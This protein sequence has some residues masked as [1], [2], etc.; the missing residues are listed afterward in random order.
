MC[1]FILESDTFSKCCHWRWRGGKRHCQHQVVIKR[2]RASQQRTTADPCLMLLSWV[3]PKPSAALAPN[4][5][6]YLAMLGQIILPICSSQVARCPMYVPCCLCASQ[7]FCPSF[8]G[9][10]QAP[11]WDHCCFFISSC[12]YTHTNTEEC[13]DGFLNECTCGLMSLSS[14]WKKTHVWF[15]K[16][17]KLQFCIAFAFLK[18]KPFLM[19]WLKAGGWWNYYCCFI[20]STMV[21][22]SLLISTPLH[23]WSSDSDM[24]QLWTKQNTTAG[25][26]WSPAEPFEKISLL[27]QQKGSATLHGG[28]QIGHPY[29]NCTKHTE[30]LHYTL[31]LAKILF[32]FNNYLSPIATSP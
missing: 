16:F 10:L 24:D 27:L 12:C 4:Y 29:R 28:P 18:S 2:W 20:S 31:T 6:Q 25:S 11:T 21:L 26:Y 9:V 19:S 23:I 15:S 32:V 22:S 8:C 14:T 13:N 1:T 5:G 17:H 7:W 3:P 30:M